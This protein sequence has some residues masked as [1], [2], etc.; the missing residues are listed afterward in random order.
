MP[1]YIDVDKTLNRL[2]EDLPYKSSV[3]RVLLQAP[4]ENVVPKS[5]VARNIIVEIAEKL[6]YSNHIFR[7]CASKLVSPQYVDGRCDAYQEFIDILD[8]IVGKYIFKE[9]EDENT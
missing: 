7:T 5:E 8:D 4:E 3:K 2:P 1:K 9:I 6:K